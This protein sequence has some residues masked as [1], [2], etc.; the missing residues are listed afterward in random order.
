MHGSHHHQ[1]N[2]SFRTITL[3]EGNAMYHAIKVW[4]ICLGVLGLQIWSKLIDRYP[5]SCK[6]PQCFSIPPFWE[7]LCFHSRDGDQI[8]LL[9]GS[10]SSFIL[11]PFIEFGEHYRLVSRAV[12]RDY[13]AVDGGEVLD[14]EGLFE[15]HRRQRNAQETS[16]LLSAKC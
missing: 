15:L 7:A 4:G 6:E 13:C 5:M 3:W 1:A 8:W 2:V 12:R 10:D 9:Y 14:T 16:D 11:R